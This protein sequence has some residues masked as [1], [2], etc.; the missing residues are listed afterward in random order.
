M[1]EVVYYPEPT[2]HTMKQH[3]TVLK[4]A[5][6]PVDKTSNGAGYVKCSQKS[7]WQCCVPPQYASGAVEETSNGAGCV[8]SRIKSVVALCSAAVPPPPLLVVEREYLMTL[9]LPDELA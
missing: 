3:N 4:Y 8:K 2:R 6:D 1:E 9:S 7:S 5:L